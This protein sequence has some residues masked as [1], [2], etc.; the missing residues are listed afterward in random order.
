VANGSN[1]VYISG[2]VKSSG[3]IPLSLSRERLL[4]IIALAGGPTNSP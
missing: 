2:D 3:Y 1:V 4:N